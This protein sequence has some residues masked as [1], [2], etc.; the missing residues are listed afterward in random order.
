MGIIIAYDPLPASLISVSGLTPSMLIYFKYI[1]EVIKLSVI[2]TSVES[3]RNRR[4]VNRVV[5]HQKEDR[6]L[7]MLRMVVA[8][9]DGAEPLP[10]E[11]K[12]TQADVDKLD[13]DGDNSFLVEKM[14]KIFND[15][16]QDGSGCIC[17]DEMDLASRGSALRLMTRSWPR[18]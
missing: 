1:F 4:M 18:S 11:D 15:I 7:A 12:P 5:R 14:D 17:K 3:M 2:C 10:L 13:A 16:D 8:M 6:A 9:N